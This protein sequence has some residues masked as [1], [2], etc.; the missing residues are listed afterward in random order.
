MVKLKK[1]KRK[2]AEL[3]KSNPIESPLMMKSLTENV[4][5]VK[6]AILMIIKKLKYRMKLITLGL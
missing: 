1:I 3:I 4:G 2:M 6:K 5:K